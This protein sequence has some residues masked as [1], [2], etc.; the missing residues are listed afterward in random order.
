MASIGTPDHECRP[1]KGTVVMYSYV[2]ESTGPDCLKS[3]PHYH[4]NIIL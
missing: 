1:T 4:V 2:L 3:K